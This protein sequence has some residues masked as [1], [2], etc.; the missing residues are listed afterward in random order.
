MEQ[1]KN[2]ASGRMIPGPDAW[3]ILAL[4]SYRLGAHGPDLTP[5]TLPSLV[6]K[7]RRWLSS[8]VLC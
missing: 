8:A 3:I 6:A 1:L 5:L 7:C 4:L 2:K